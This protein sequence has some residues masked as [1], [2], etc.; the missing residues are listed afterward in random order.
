MPEPRLIQE[1]PKYPSDKIL[2]TSKMLFEVTI[3]QVQD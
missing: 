1:A 3:P 2:T